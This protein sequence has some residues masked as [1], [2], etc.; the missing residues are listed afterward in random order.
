MISDGKCEDMHWIQQI[1]SRPINR[2]TPG[3][4]KFI[5]EK[6]MGFVCSHIFR[7]IHMT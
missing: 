3:L 2:V 7:I 5:K 6:D 1:N 4:D